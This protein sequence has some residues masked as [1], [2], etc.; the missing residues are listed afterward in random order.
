MVIDMVGYGM[1][2][3]S[4][5]GVVDACGQLKGLMAM[6]GG[7]GGGCSS[8]GP[9]SNTAVFRGYDAS[10]A[11]FKFPVSI[12]NFQIAVEAEGKTLCIGRGGE[13]RWCGKD[14]FM[15]VSHV[16]EHGWQGTS[17]DGVCSRTLD[18]LLDVA[19]LFDLEWV[20][21][22]VALISGVK[23][24][25]ATS[26]NS[27]G[28]VYSSAK[29]TVVW[30]RLLLAASSAASSPREVAFLI[31]LT[32]WMTRVWTMQEALLSSY[33]VFMFRDT[34]VKGPELT[35]SLIDHAAEPALH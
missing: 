5:K 8:C 32:D 27:M 33:L 9:G 35:E 29:V 3:P 30:D 2:V 28:L 21:L 13:L 25:R 16:W 11:C 24:V 15:A 23:E 31:Y 10:S 12:E 18:L 20:W 19:E 26:V 34:Y 7:V 17:E 22:D 1:D 4:A 14:E 6:R